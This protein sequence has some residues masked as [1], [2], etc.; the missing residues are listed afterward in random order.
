[1]DI[2]ESIKNQ[3]VKDGIPEF[4]IGDT[5]RFRVKVVEGDKERYQPFQGS[6]I[7]KQGSGGE[8]TFTV[9]K[10]SGNIGVE[11][12]F[13]LHSPNLSDFQVISRG[14]IRRSKL[15]YLRKLSGKKA[16]ISTRRDF[17]APGKKS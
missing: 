6:V 8:E 13:P 16:R 1:M 15:Y 9:R 17:T 11:R 3:Q 10:I 2:V 7:C 5:I 4:N 12:I 14:K